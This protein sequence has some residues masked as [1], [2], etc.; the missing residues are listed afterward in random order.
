MKEGG[1]RIIQ[2]PPA[3]GYPKGIEIESKDG[4]TEYLVPPNAKLQYELELVSVAA[5]PP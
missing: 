1:T 4:G 2:V 5:P 3:L